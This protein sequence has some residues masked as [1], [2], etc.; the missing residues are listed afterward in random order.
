MA[1]FR[2][3]WP[4]KLPPIKTRDRIDDIPGVKVSKAHATKFAVNYKNRLVGFIRRDMSTGLFGWELTRG[5]RNL[6]MYG[7]FTS[8]TKRAAVEMFI[9]Y[10]DAIDGDIDG[11]LNRKALRDREILEM[12]RREQAEKSL[13]T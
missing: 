1:D 4:P 7:P 9:S 5:D 3:P 2:G 10:I 12:W 11:E 13:S 6:S 8:P